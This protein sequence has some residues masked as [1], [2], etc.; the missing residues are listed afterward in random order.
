MSLSSRRYALLRRLG[1]ACALAVL[2]VTSLSAYMRLSKAG[3]GCDDWPACYG[4]QQRA[5]A[6][7]L[8]PPP[9]EAG[10]IASARLL[11]RV[12]AVFVLLAALVM[13]ML[14]F[15]RKAPMRGEGVLALLIVLLA[16]ALAVLGR[17]SSGVHVPAVALG[18]LLGGFAMLALCARL[19][20]AGWIAGWPRLRG[21]AWAAAALL[22]L[23]LS[24]G[25]LVSASFAGLSCASGS[26][27]S[28]WAAWQQSGWQSLD[29]WREPLANSPPP[30]NPAGMFS[31]SLHRHLAWL[32]A[33]ALLALAW[34][35]WRRR[36][37]RTAAL[38]ACLVAMQLL[39]G[40]LLVPLGLP[41]AL[42][43]LHNLLAALLLAAVVT[44]I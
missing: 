15:D 33:P 38:L 7:G 35:A 30:T 31:H 36:R 34:L 11:H 42:A 4:Q 40:I 25:G 29:P 6:Q 16:V 20:V 22:L 37:P 18:N 26:E 43:L 23:Q 13:L 24:L 2:V 44:L 21:W 3:L 27:C 9:G 5:A 1:L 8:A 28:L 10:V 17:W 41:L 19:S 14:C 12:M 39:A 32:T